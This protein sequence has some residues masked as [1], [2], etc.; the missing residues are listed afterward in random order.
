MIAMLVVAG[1]CRS[2]LSLCEDERRLLQVDEHF[3]PD[4]FSLV[5][6]YA[7]LLCTARNE[8]IESL[9]INIEENITSI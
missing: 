2:S 5:F 3:A 9:L 7:L 8:L 1:T 6:G 4:T